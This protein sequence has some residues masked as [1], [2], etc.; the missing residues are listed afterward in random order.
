[1]DQKKDHALQSYFEARSNIVSWEQRQHTSI[2][3]YLGA[4]TAVLGGQLGLLQVVDDSDRPVVALFGFLVSCILSLTMYALACSLMLIIARL[5]FFCR[6]VIQSEHKAE[7][8]VFWESWLKSSA[9]TIKKPRLLESTLGIFLLP[10]ILSLAVCIFFAANE[11][12]FTIAALVFALAT[13]IGLV[14]QFR[15]MI[16]HLDSAA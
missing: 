4:Y 3:F 8:L 11:P 15:R 12:R 7:E 6:Q 9:N 2:Q 14:V 13:F 5:A 10:V 1:M 16:A